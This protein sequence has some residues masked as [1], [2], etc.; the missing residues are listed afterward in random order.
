M[1]DLADTAEVVMIAAE[2]GDAV[3]AIWAREVQN[4]VVAGLMPGHIFWS[5]QGL[6]EG[7]C[8]AED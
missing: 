5:D 8:L 2:V 4:G 6:A 3:P 7:K 1:D